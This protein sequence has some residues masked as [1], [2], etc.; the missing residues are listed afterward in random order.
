MK[1]TVLFIS[2][3]HAVNTIPSAYQHLFHQHQSIL[4][5]HR[6]I[7]FGALET[8]THLSEVFACD[9]NK[10]TVSRLLIDCNRSLTSTNCFSEFTKHLPQIEKQKIIDQYYLPYRNRCESLIKTHI[11]QGNQVLH[12]SIHSFTPVFKGVTRNAGIGLLYDP[13]RH[14]E[15]EVTREWHSLLSHEKPTYRVR[16][17]YPYSGTSDGFTSALRKKY[18]EHEYLGIEVE[19]NQALVMKGKE[20]LDMMSH[21]LSRSLKELL[22]LL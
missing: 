20:A 13:K 1:P 19:M 14:G 8:A 15:K 4:E 11:Q 2:C 17:N 6:G 9:F 12:L 7:D 16:M 22:L 18:T 5:T 3:E 10:A 21:A